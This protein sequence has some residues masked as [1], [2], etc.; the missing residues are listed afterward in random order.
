MKSEINNLKN[1][2]FFTSKTANSLLEEKIKA[3]EFQV[4]SKID[5]SNSPGRPLINSVNCH[6]SRISELVDYCLQ[7]EVK[8]FEWYVKDTTYF[9]KKIEDIDHVSHYSYLGSLDVCSLYTSI[10]HKEGIE[11]VKQKL[12]NSKPGISIKFILKFLKLILTLDNFVINSINYLQKKGCALGTK[13]AP[14]YANIFM[15]VLRKSLYF[16]FRQT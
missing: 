10:P 5:K 2:N 16:H 15:V 14:S 8:K 12:K 13:C 4:L 11:S 3:P 7:P 6:S 1:E 9:I